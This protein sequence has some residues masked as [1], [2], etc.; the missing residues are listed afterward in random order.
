ME[1]QTT[2]LLEKKPIAD[3]VIELRFVKPK[4]FIFTAGQFI[5]V[6]VPQPN[7]SIFRSY[8]ISSTSADKYLELCV[9][10]YEDGLGSNLFQQLKNG[11]TITFKGPV[12]RF[13]HTHQTENSLFV[14]TGVGLAPIFG[15]IRD[16]LE[17]KKNQ[18]KLHLI[19]GVRHEK[20]IFWKNRLDELQKNYSNFTY[21]LT[22]SQPEDSW[23]GLRGRVTE[24]LPKNTS[25]MHAFLCGNADMV[26]TVREML[27]TQGTEV[28]K[29][30]FEIF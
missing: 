20:D 26:K 27:I 23:T 4:N 28:N 21:S 15:M 11:D 25:N 29:I 2:T 13:T 5:Q 30:H 22:L 6:E 12:G 10:L 19:F 8:S 14:A 18:N 17:N 16:E 1:L 3:Q 24:H 7:K 9:K